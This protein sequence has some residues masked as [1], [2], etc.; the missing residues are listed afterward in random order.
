MSRLRILL[1]VDVE[2]YYMSPE[3]IPVSDW[4]GYEDR[5]E[6]GMGRLLDLFA[7]GGH[8]ATFFFLGYIAERH[9]GLVRRAAEE[10]HEIGT[11]THDHRPVYSLSPEGFRES[12]HRSVETL[13][14]AI[15]RPVVSHRAPAFSLRRGSRWMWDALAGEGIRYDSS[16]NPVVTYLYGERGA[17]RTPYLIAAEPHA[18]VEVPPSA[19]EI[20]PGRR[21]PAGGGG[22]LRA[23]PLAYVRWA[24]GRLNRE[25][26]P[27]VIYVHPWEL[28]PDHP[29][30]RLRGKEKWVHEWG[31]SGFAGKLQRLLDGA[32]TL[33]LDG[34]AA[35]LTDLPQPAERVAAAA[36]PSG[37][38]P[39]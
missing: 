22:F 10:G 33:R 11:H 18:I 23:L 5:I 13:A 9:P 38:G 3:S 36:P 28:D 26:F 7:A 17:P 24:V 14:G 12:L 25:G 30:P 27:A 19:V 4:G 6:I 32:E 39:E 34:Y 35:S 16:V 21:L 29:R 20:P 2:D 15:G 8:T 31:L 1:T 37:R